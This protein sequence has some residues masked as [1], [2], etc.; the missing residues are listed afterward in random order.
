MVHDAPRRADD[1]VDARAQAS[2]LA[3]VGLPAVDGEDGDVA[4]AAEV[5]DRLRHLHRQFARGGE[6][7]RLHLAPRGV[8]AL[9]EGEREGGGLAGAGLRLREHIVP[10]EQQGDGLR[11]DGRGFLEAE[12][13]DGAQ[14]ISIEVEFEE[15]RGHGGSFKTAGTREPA[16]CPTPRVRG[17]ADLPCWDVSA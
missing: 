9:H 10:G 14:H 12:R 11:L 2:E 15:G 3:V 4:G 5:V 1:D 13:V 8:D 7:E 6:D 17:R 16:L